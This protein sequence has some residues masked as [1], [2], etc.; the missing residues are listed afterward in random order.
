MARNDKFL[1]IDKFLG[2]NMRAR[3]QE[4]IQPTVGQEQPGAWEQRIARNVD[5]TGLGAGKGRNSVVRRTGYEKIISLEAA[6]SGFRFEDG[7]LCGSAE[8]I[9]LVNPKNKAYEV[10]AVPANSSALISWI[11]FNGTVY[12]ANGEECGR[13]KDETAE[14]WGIERAGRPNLTVSSSGG[15]PAGRYQVVCLFL[16]GSEEGSAG[17]G[18]V[19]SVPEG[20]GI[21][22]SSIPQPTD[23]SITGIRIYVTKQNGEVFLRHSD[24]AVGTTSVLLTEKAGLG[25]RLQT[26][27]MAQPPVGSLLARRNA[28]VAI[29]KGE[30]LY[31]CLPQRPWLYV[32][33][34]GIF[35]FSAPIRMV[36]PVNDGFFVDADRLYFLR[37]V[38]REE[39]Y[40]TQMLPEDYEAIPR[41]L[42]MVPP[43]WFGIEG[44]EAIAFWWTT[45]GFPVIGL[46]GGQLR[47][48][49]ADKMAVPA[50]SKAASLLREREGIRQL[51]TAF[52][53]DAPRSKLGASDALEVTINK[54]GNLV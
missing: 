51:L 49:S 43:F 28:D 37:W 54:R 7:I 5:L 25:K 36:A 48:V 24:V 4:L 42:I 22:L 33:M 21:Q 16:R 23:S 18:V 11:E 30:F 39:V 35:P 9:C 1:E 45:R 10:L 17:S 20:G 44:E 3:E 47:P 13:I 12:W 29:A 38:S 53:D 41:S 50:Y 27:F 46:P 14:P 2:V 15:M 32:P 19:V 34:T 6:H 8:G 31:V 52:Y 26:Q 40:K